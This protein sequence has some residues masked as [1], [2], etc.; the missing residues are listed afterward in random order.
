MRLSPPRPFG[1]AGGIS[2][3]IGDTEDLRQ[4]VGHIGYH[5]YPKAQGQHLAE[6]ACRLILP[7]AKANDL[8]ELWITC[9]PEN[10]ASRR[11]CERLGATL[12]DTVT[13]PIDHPLRARGDVAKC[14]YK[15][16]L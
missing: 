4:W 15:L 12:V 8:D 3:R 6:R 9:N 14:R 2:L 13:V 11:T 5:V 16:T 7:L 1:I 10:A